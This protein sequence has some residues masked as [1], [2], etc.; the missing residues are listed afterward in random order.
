MPKTLGRGFD[1]RRLHHLEKDN[2]SAGWQVGFLFP[3][4]SKDDCTLLAWEQAYLYQIGEET[5]SLKPVPTRY[6]L[7]C[8]G[9]VVLCRL[10][11]LDICS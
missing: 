2:L 4:V 7:K 8:S 6:F 1:S 11:I 3:L 10:I 5:V 9:T